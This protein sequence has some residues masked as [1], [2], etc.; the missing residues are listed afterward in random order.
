M[1]ENPLGWV[2][3][4]AF[5]VLSKTDRP[6]NVLMGKINKNAPWDH[7]GGLDGG[8]VERHSKKWMLPYSHLILGEDP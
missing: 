4:S 7:I 6:S 5:I 2:C 3:L 1:S 8:R